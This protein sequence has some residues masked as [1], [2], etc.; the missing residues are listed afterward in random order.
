MNLQ[1]HRSE[2]HYSHL[3]QSFP[4][5]NVAWTNL[6]RI[7]LQYNLRRTTT[8]ADEL[9]MHACEHLSSTYDDHPHLTHSPLSNYAQVE[10]YDALRIAICTRKRAQVPVEITFESRAHISQVT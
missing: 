4:S 6:V 8:F 2:S 5:L 10:C 1:E 7:V 3:I 9:P